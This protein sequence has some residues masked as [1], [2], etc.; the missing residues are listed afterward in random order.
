[1][2]ISK[3]VR[4]NKKGVEISTQ[5][6]NINEPTEMQ[7]IKEAAAGNPNILF[8]VPNT[9]QNKKEEP[10]FEDEIQ[11]EVDESEKQWKEK[12]KQFEKKYERIDIH[13][14][15]TLEKRLEKLEEENKKLKEFK[16][17]E[18][19]QK[20]N[21]KRGVVK[22]QIEKFETTITGLLNAQKLVNEYPELDSNELIRISIDCKRDNTNYFDNICK[23]SY[24]PVIIAIISETL[25][26]SNIRLEKLK[27]EKA[28]LDSQLI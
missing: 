15:E 19:L 28:D 7:L 17:F 1:M 27:I 3:D 23:I 4:K 9:E 8:V 11:K 26:Q 14:L 25:N 6:E 24:N 12:E 5:I 2:T 21:E 16:S 22:N 10:S 20:I 18:A 13:L